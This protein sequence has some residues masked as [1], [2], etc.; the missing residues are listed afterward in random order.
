MFGGR[1]EPYR[2]GDAPHP[3]EPYGAAKAD[4]ETAVFA[5]HPGSV[6]VRTSLLLGDGDGD[7]DL[8]QPELDAVRAASGEHTFTF[9]TDELR[10]PARAI[11]VAHALMRLITDRRDVS[12]PLHIAGPEPLDR[13]ALAR[14]IVTS[15]GLDSDRLATATTAE[16]GLVGRRP[17]RVVL[18][19]GRAEA[20]GLTCRPV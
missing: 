10:S 19:V 2:E 16:L 6:I 9:F 3:V 5:T 12:G 1:D 20:L 4:A 8:G 14:R 17:G 18:D 7:H 11:D 15:R 13:A